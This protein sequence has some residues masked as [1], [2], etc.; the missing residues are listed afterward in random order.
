MTEINDWNG[1]YLPD[2]EPTMILECTFCMAH[3]PFLGDG[4]ETIADGQFTLPEYYIATCP[5]C[6]GIYGE[7]DVVGV[8]EPDEAEIKAA[9]VQA[10]RARPLPMTGTDFHRFGEE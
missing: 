3:I 5:R 4:D 8:I 10:Q 1:A 2:D 6:G 7:G 9:I